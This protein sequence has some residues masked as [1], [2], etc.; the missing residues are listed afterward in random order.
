MPGL[1]LLIFTVSL[2]KNGD[3]EVRESTVSGDMSSLWFCVEVPWTIICERLSS[4]EALW[5][6][7]GKIWIGSASSSSR[8]T[9][10]SLLPNR[11]C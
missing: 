2:L 7:R 10:E 1:G 5:K 6:M 8:H 9:D 3:C 4:L 11:T